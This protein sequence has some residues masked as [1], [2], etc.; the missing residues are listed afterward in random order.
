MN[1]RERMICAAAAAFRKR[2]GWS[3][4]DFA[5]Q[6]GV[7]LNQWASIEYGRTPLRYDLAWKMRTLFGVSLE[8]LSVGE[9]APDSTFNDDLPSPEATGLSDSALL[10]DVSDKVHGAVPDINYNAKPQKEVKL[11]KNELRHRA[12]TAYALRRLID[13][14]ISKV[15]DGYTSDFSDKLMKL[16]KV[17]MDALP[18]EPDNIVGAR[19]DDLTWDSMRREL[20]NRLGD[21]G[22]A[23]SSSL[24]H[25]SE[26]VNNSSVTPNLPELLKR[27]KRATEQ[28]G[29]KS[30]LAKFLGVSLVQVSQWLAGDR[31]PGG[32]VTLRMLQWVQHQETK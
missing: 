27:L 4:K 29:Q 2:V 19:I 30:A 26:S 32:K 22:S 10:S 21:G 31:E 1:D 5:A 17:Y 9:F 8:W 13:V 11:D 18:K 14:W 6:L 3:Q 16:A 15:P 23:K 25:V 7:S 12:F 24:T 28:R 20:R